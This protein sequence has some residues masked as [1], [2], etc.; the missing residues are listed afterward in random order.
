MGQTHRQHFGPLPLALWACPMLLLLLVPLVALMGSASPSDIWT[1]MQNPIFMPALWLSAKT[2]F[3]SLLVIVLAGTPLAWWMATA[4]PHQR[5]VVTLLV[6]LPIVIPP[7]VLG[8]A[9]LQ[10]FGRQGLLGDI[11]QSLGIQIPFSTSAVILAQVVVAA[12]F[13]IQSA[14]TAFRRV[15]PDFLWVARTLGQKPAGAFLQVALPLA[16]PGMI[17]GAALSWARALGEFG[18]TLLFAG[19]LSE[20]TQTMPLAIYTAMESDVRAAVAISLVLVAVAFV[21]L[22]G[23]R[24]LPAVNPQTTAENEGGMSS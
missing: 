1:G 13:Y 9:L 14:T 6:D 17:S 11:F 10:T 4:T 19:N 22:L 15:N 12:P 18:A 16:L 8:I 2:S 24:L 20:T 23:L 3:V 21:L 7:A 5:K